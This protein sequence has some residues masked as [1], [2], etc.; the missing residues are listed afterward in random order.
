M[1]DSLEAAL[2]SA[3]L[4]SREVYDALQSDLDSG[5]F[6]EW[7][8][9]VVRQAAAF[10]GADP[11]TQS[12]DRGL[13]ES[14]LGR[15]IPNPKH[16]ASALRYVG[17]LPPAPSL[18]NVVGEYR[19][20]RRHNVGLRLAACLAS[21]DTRGAEPL[22]ADYARL[23]EQTGARGAK[24]TVE[25]LEEQTKLDG[26]IKIVPKRLNELCKGRLMRGHHI[27][28]FARPEVGKTGW[29][30]N[31]ASGFLKQGL[32]VLHGGNEE[33]VR[34]LQLRYL[35]RLSGTP[36]DTLYEPG[37]IRVAVEAAGAAYGRLAA[38]E[39]VTGRMSELEG[40]V[41]RWKPD[42][43][44]VDQLRNLH[45]ASHGNRTQELD[46]A[47]RAVR[48]LAKNH[49]LVAVSITQAGDSAAEK[50]KLTMGDVDW[51]NTGIQAAAD[52]LLGIGATEE[53]ERLNKRW[54]EVLKN[55]IGGQKGGF[56][57]WVDWDTGVWRSSPPPLREGS[58]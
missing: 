45:M 56:P 35:S 19:A 22:L 42:V 57:V 55:K 51:S 33:P 9:Y 15:A 36:L 38:V 4:Q 16:L 10:Y 54:V 8:R 44:V 20:L 46:E 12:V 24:L 1:I 47:A 43:V 53:F 39:L 18:A 48:D 58:V 14:A 32:K 26:A 7:G 52:L 37:A 40:M 25:E 31:M 41:K 28:V 29:T 13:L 17:E 23:G 6:S 3:I 21:G 5:E 11:T 27:V 50:L 30:V 34:D 49:N 2:V